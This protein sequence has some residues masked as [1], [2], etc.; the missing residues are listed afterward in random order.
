MWEGLL[1]INFQPLQDNI[2]FGTVLGSILGALGLH[3]GRILGPKAFQE[4]LGKHDK[5]KAKTRST[6]KVP[7]LNRAVLAPPSLSPPEPSP[8]AQAEGGM[9]TKAVVRLRQRV[10]EPRLK[11]KL[12]LN[13]HA[14]R[15]GIASSHRGSADFRF[16]RQSHFRY[17]F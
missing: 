15:H 5:K 10:G 17:Y 8:R 11:R 14:G 13:S 6:K 12:W 3:F 9:S 4:R 16:G 2:E 7:K 1:E